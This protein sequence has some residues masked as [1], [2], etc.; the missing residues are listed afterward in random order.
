MDDRLTYGSI[1]QLKTAIQKYQNTYF[2][3]DKVSPTY[4]SLISNERLKE[5]T[6]LYDTQTDK[7]KD[8]DGTYIDEIILVHHEKR[9]YALLNYLMTG[10]YVVITFNQETTPLKG[11]ITKTEKDM[12]VIDDKYYIDFQYCG[13]LDDYNIE[14]IELEVPPKE[15][16]KQNSSIEE[17]TNDENTNEEYVFTYDVTQQIQD[18]INTSDVKGNQT[19]KLQNEIQKYLQLRNEYKLPKNQVLRSFLYL[20][21]LLFTLSTSRVK[22]VKYDLG[23]F[24]DEEK[25]VILKDDLRIGDIEEEINSGIFFDNLIRSHEKRHMKVK[26]ASSIRVILAYEDENE[27]L[28]IYQLTKKESRYETQEVYYIEGQVD[29]GFIFSPNGIILHEKEKLDKNINLQK[30]QYLLS[31]SIQNENNQFTKNVSIEISKPDNIKFKEN[32]KQFI[33]NEKEVSKWN[34]FVS[35][36]PF[37]LKNMYIETKRGMH[38]NSFDFM[39]HFN[40]FDIHKIHKRDFTWMSQYMQKNK[41]EVKQ[42]IYLLDKDYKKSKR[43]PY[44]YRENNELHNIICSQYKKQDIETSHASEIF[45]E[46]MQD[47]GILMMHFLRK[48]SETLRVPFEDSEVLSLV[49]ELQ[50]DFETNKSEIENKMKQ[51][52]KEHVKTYASLQE[53][54][55]DTNKTILKDIDDEAF[56]NPIHYLHS[57]LEANHNYTESIEVFNVKLQ[58]I[59]GLKDRIRDKDFSIDSL[60]EELFGN[61]NASKKEEIFQALNKEIIRLTVRPNDKCYVESEKEY[62]IYDKD[63]KW[64]KIDQYQEKLNKKKVLR[65]Q[66]SVNEFDEIKANMYNDY[67][68]K[69]IDKMQ[70]EKVIE[71]E[72]KQMSQIYDSTKLYYGLVKRKNNHMRNLLQYNNNMLKLRNNF[73]L[74]AYLSHIDPSPYEGLMYHILSLEND[75]ER[76]YDLILHFVSLLTLDLHD[77]DW[78]YCIIKKTKLMPKFLHRLAL[79]YN[80]AHY[81]NTIKEIC[82]QEG[83]LSENGDA[84]IHKNTG[85]M[86]QKISFD[87][88]YGYDSNGYKISQDQVIEKDQ[89]MDEDILME[90]SYIDKGENTWKYEK[91]IVLGPMEKELYHFSSIIMNIL[92]IKVFQ[93]YEYG[94]IRTIFHIYEAS[95][96]KIKKKEMKMKHFVYSVFG[97]LL[98]FI[99]SNHIYVKKT[100][101]GCMTDFTGYPLELQEEN[102]NGIRFLGCL[103]EKLSKKNE[104][105]P[106]V[107]FKRSKQQE[108]ASELFEFVK[109]YVITNEDVASMLETKR[110]SLMIQGPQIKNMDKYSNYKQFRPRLKTFTTKAM[111]EFPSF[112]DQKNTYIHSLHLI[113]EMQYLHLQIEEFLQ[114]KVADEAPLLS[115]QSY[116]EPFLVNFCCNQSKYILKHLCKTKEEEIRMKNYFEKDKHLNEVLRNAIEVYLSNPKLGFLKK[117]MYD[118]SNDSKHEIDIETIYRYII[119]Y[120]NFDNER[121]IPEFLKSMVPNKPNDDI[122]ISTD[123]MVQKIAKLQDHG[124]KYNEETLLRALFLQNKTHYNEPVVS[125]ESNIENQNEIEQLHK[126]RNMSLEE[127]DSLSETMKSKLLSFTR[128]YKVNGDFENI[129]NVLDSFDRSK[130]KESIISFLSQANYHLLSV[131]PYKLLND[132]YKNINKVTCKHWN[133]DENH[134]K[135]IQKHMQKNN[136]F[137]EDIDVH[138]Y[139]RDFLQI[140]MKCRDIDKEEKH[141]KNQIHLFSFYQCLFFNILYYFSIL[142]FETARV[143]NI[144]NIQEINE[145]LYPYMNHIL[146]HICLSYEDLELHQNRLKQSE[147]KIKTDKLKNKNKIEREVERYKMNAKLDEW[148]YGLGKR[149]RIYDASLYQDESK[150]ASDVKKSYLEIYG[151]DGFLQ[152][153][154]PPMEEITQD[155]KVF[156]EE[157][158]QN[159][160]ED[161]E[162]VNQENEY[163]DDWEN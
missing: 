87:T 116:N 79:A 114:N 78:Y 111:D 81:Q 150:R 133:L 40:L 162:Y 136:G 13:L 91:V 159:C 90:D 121:P 23:V 50:R 29:K 77:P 131:I 126:L 46:T 47:N 11:Y 27:L 6:I 96:K 35:N 102:L 48:A 8:M 61:L 155:D 103:L 39:Q 130:N 10:K 115:S 52:Q 33:R 63:K 139:S 161:D 22:E 137:L 110:H 71:L 38:V 108:I 125:Q 157:E 69:L 75:L 56:N 70:N 20:N 86:I 145:K 142:D 17:N 100:F 120:G 93:R 18:Y 37:D 106:Y 113:N 21:D 151:D 144:K 127:L 9:G 94:Y 80:H 132:S 60:K 143:S 99:Q 30:G 1:I 65:Y 5:E 31:K 122:Y 92:G 88:N 34:E 4:M 57:Y 129:C 26:P 149:V 28:P 82:L 158:E 104:N 141:E 41:E 73:D 140:L 147:K 24:S 16:K 117:N 107:L 154:E 45:Q 152:V 55:D 53:L 49:E 68:L 67:A 109:L 98:C 51:Q 163:L 146:K 62:Y 105:E 119:Y 95:L 72:Q 32:T 128:K 83:C 97:F 138:E 3:V 135:E 118:S 54:Q 36:I 124:H 74:H 59:L 14:S 76:K 43:I 84:W 25:N 7:W 153:H 85:M 148:S 12:I 64:V 134:A 66:K 160:F 42:R 19:K 123:T 15:E 2:F 112:K 156:Q 44:V 89:V 101:P 58:K